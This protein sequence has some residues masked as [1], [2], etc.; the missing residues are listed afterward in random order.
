[1]TTKPSVS[2]SALAVAL[3]AAALAAPTIAEEK[4]FDLGLRGN[5]GLGNGVPTNDIIGYGL[6]GH[7]RFNERWSIGFAV[8]YSP[9]FDFERTPDTLGFVTEMAVDAKGTSTGFSTWIERV[10]G[11]SGGKNEWFWNAG[12]GLNSVDM[13]D[14]SGPLVGGGDFNITTDAGSELMVMAGGGY[15]RWFGP[16]WGLEGALSLGRHSAD[17]KVMDRVSGATRTIDDY[18]VNTIRLGILKRF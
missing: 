14:I 9:E 7:Y 8:D 2:T 12:L 4:K 11:R 1:M 17:W 15:R 13:K 18:S 6:F 16:G 3:F 5:I 10:Y